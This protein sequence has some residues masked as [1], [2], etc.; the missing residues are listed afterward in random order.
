[1]LGRRRPTDCKPPS[2]G[3]QTSPRGSERN[4][5]LRGASS[6]LP[7]RC[8]PGPG[9]HQSTPHKLTAGVRD[10]AASGLA[11]PQGSPEPVPTPEP[12]R[13]IP[14]A[15]SAWGCFHQPILRLC[16]AP[17]DD[18]VDRLCVWTVPR[19]LCQPST[20][21]EG[22]VVAEFP[23]PGRAEGL[24]KMERHVRSDRCGRAAPLSAG[25]PFSCVLEDLDVSW[26]M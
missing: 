10:E 18:E 26:L 1:M 2:T 4:P 25:S 23:Q 16:R 20:K 17:R 8:V 6:P 24:G 11:P 14:E 7:Q 12:P 3:S 5:P 21:S 15:D 13:R 22:R 9:V 19:T